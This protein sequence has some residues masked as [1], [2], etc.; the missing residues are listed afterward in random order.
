VAVAVAVAQITQY[1]QVIVVV[2][3]V[4]VVLAYLVKAVTAQAGQ[5]AHQD[6]AVK[7]VQAAVVAA[8]VLM[9]HCLAHSLA[10]LAGHLAGQAVKVDSALLDAV[11][12]LFTN[13]A[14]RAVLALCVLSGPDAHVHSQQLVLDHHNF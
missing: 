10:G 4:V 6:A 5:V 7:V 3:A 11:A 9:D 13:Q 12:Q 14:E 8:M 1:P 2:L